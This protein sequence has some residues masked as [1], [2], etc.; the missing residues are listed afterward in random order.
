MPNTANTTMSATVTLDAPQKQPGFFRRLLKSP[1][2]VVGI[3]IIA[4]YL[5]VALA[6]AFELTP[7]SPLQQNRLDRLQAPSAT[8]RMGT[9]LYGRDVLSRVIDGATN[10]LRVALASVLLSGVA[11]TLLGALSG[12][13][14]GLTDHVIMRVMDVFFA[15]PAILLALLVVVVLGPGLNNTILAIAVVYTPIFARVARGPTLSVREMD[16]VTAARCLG[17]SER[18]ILLLHVLPNILA[19]LI[20]Q[21]SLALSW[22]LLTEAGLSFL[23]LGTRPPQ[24]SWGVMLSESRALAEIAPWLMLYPGLAIMLGV[25][26]FNL[27]GD[28]LRDVLDPRLRGKR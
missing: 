17:V 11:G 5:G 18:R 15:F 21:I 14:G 19:P 16:Y 1:S 25:L 12:F 6:G 10:S 4:F 24:A 3:V 7:H 28:G 26:G 22:S 23:G 13:A 20:V 9:D 8:Y 2:G 27:L